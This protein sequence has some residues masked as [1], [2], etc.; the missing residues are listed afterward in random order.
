LYSFEEELL[1]RFFEE[2]FQKITLMNGIKDITPEE[3]L[4]KINAL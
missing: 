2:N 4:D 1:I 3:F